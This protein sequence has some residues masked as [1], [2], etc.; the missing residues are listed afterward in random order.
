MN[1]KCCSL[2]EC[3][4]APSWSKDKEDEDWIVR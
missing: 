1:S 4:M 3:A 2:W